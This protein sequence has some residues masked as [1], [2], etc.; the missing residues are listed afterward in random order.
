MAKI[1]EHA[2]FTD[3]ELRQLI[4]NSNKKI[5]RLIQ[6]YGDSSKIN[7][8]QMQK[9]KTDPLYGKLYQQG[10]NNTYKLST[11]ISQLTQREKQ[12]MYSELFF[13]F[14]KPIKGISDYKNLA[15]DIIEDEVIEEYVK[16]LLHKDEI[17]LNNPQ[18]IDQIID[19]YY[20]F[21]TAIQQY[22]AMNIDIDTLS[23]EAAEIL[24][25]SH[26]TYAELQQA[27]EYLNQAMIDRK[28]KK[29]KD[30]NEGAI[31]H[32]Q[33]RRAYLEDKIRKELSNQ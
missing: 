2:K 32:E 25:K 13:N 1:M 5:D 31:L 30:K 18:D 9:L 19:V 8:M 33:Q 12:Q 11:D 20:D 28:Q 24:H 15:S 10:I 16:N 7:K 14:N 3:K 22:K 29:S 21:T 27:S 4:R 23:P 6:K 17:D 26:K